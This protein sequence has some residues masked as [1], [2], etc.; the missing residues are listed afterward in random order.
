MTKTS[1]TIVAALVA[2]A[3][4]S[5]AHA[6]HSAVKPAVSAPSESSLTGSLDV[7]VASDYVYHGQKLDSNPVVVPRLSLAYPLTEGARVEVS[8]QQVLG[9]RGDS[10]Y[11]TQY[12]AGLAL[13]IG[14]FTLTPGVEL[15]NSP[16]N[17]FKDSQAVTARLSFDDS[18]LNLLPL[19][20]NPYVSVLARVDSG[21]GS[22]WE[23]G[24][25]PSK[26]AGKLLLSVPVAI[27]AG[28]SEYYTAGKSSLHYA[29]ASAGLSATYKVTDRLSLNASSVA[30]T[31][32][33][34]LGN[35]GKGNFITSRAGVSVS[36]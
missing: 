21:K 27:G 14:S 13:K 35:S 3:F 31:T 20:L 23:V 5:S 22:T 32:D 8:V 28:A 25:A 2:A 11:R 4:T 34:R 30:Y 12:N 6:G 1:N 18:G 10:W 26:S 29:Y 36:F 15:A 9:T 16:S 33:D 24:V 19:A 7:N 17:S